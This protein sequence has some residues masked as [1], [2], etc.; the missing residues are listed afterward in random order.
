LRE[1]KLAINNILN[2]IIEVIKNHPYKI[3][4][5]L[6]LSTVSWTSLLCRIYFQVVNLLEK[7]IFIHAKVI[8][9]LTLANQLANNPTMSNIEANIIINRVTQHLLDISLV[10]HSLIINLIRMLQYIKD[11][12]TEIIISV[13]LTSTALEPTYSLGYFVEISVALTAALQVILSL[14]LVEVRFL[15]RW[16]QS[17]T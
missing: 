5:G 9:A 3:A 4:I 12:L 14:V 1:D 8:K 2:S 7:Q 10:I 17:K 6:T 16:Y 15:L 11:H 13:R